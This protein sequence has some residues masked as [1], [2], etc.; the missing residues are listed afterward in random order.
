MAQLAHSINWFG[1]KYDQSSSGTPVLVHRVRD[2]EKNATAP[3]GTR[4][5]T[6]AKLSSLRDAVRSF[7]VALSANS[8]WNQPAEVAAQL[9]QHRLTAGEVLDTFTVTPRAAT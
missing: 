4:V 2:L 6:E 9:R 5:M 1:T 8:T 3:S 7:A